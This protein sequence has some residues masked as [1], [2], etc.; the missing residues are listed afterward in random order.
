VKLDRLTIAA[1][2]QTFVVPLDPPM[3]SLKDARER[4]V[5]MDKQ[6]VAGLNRSPVT[7]KEYRPPKG[8]PA[9]LFAACLGTY[10]LHSRRENMLPGSL[11]YELILKHVPRFTEF[12]LKTR[13]FVIWPMLGIHIFETSIMTSTLKKHSVPL[14]S[15][16]WWMWTLSCF[17]E[18]IDSFRR[19]F[20]SND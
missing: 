3:S 2:G 1:G 11:P 19:Y 6:S 17:V 15:R 18:G 16:L 7:L 8:F 9:V 5:D 4:L 20:P 14:F 10:L 12:A 13:D